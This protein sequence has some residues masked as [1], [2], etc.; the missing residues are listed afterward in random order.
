TAAGFASRLHQ[1]EQILDAQHAAT[2]RQ[3]RDYLLTALLP[4]AEILHAGDEPRAAGKPE[5]ASRRRG[6]F[7]LPLVGV[8]LRRVVLALKLPRGIR[9][10]RGLAHAAL[11][12]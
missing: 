4:L 11:A 7:D 9:E 3:L 1:A 2:F 6:V 5:A 12:D 10:Y 8:G